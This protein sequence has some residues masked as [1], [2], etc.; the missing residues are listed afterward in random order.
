M[1]N[2]DGLR[3]GYLSS[4][5]APGDRLQEFTPFEKS[6]LRSTVRSSIWPGSSSLAESFPVATIRECDGPSPGV[7]GAATVRERSVP[8]KSPVLPPALAGQ[9]S[10]LQTVV[11]LC[12]QAP[13]GGSGPAGLLPAAVI[14]QGLRR[15]AEAS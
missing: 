9:L 2:R 7:N 8:L 10:A 6:F 15:F 13:G 11:I 12:D 4:R 3:A 1:K 5:H 14:L